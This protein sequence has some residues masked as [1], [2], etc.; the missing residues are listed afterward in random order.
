MNTWIVEYKLDTGELQS[1]RVDGENI[2]EAYI[3]FRIAWG[4]VW[5]NAIVRADD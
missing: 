2:L 4:K 1:F 3:N 5:I